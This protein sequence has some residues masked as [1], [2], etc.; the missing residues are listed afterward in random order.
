LSIHYY[1][2]LFHE[3]I[4]FFNLLYTNVLYICQIMDDALMDDVIT[5]RFRKT[6]MRAISYSIRD[7]NHRQMHAYALRNPAYM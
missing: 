1:T 7:M 3:N 2:L 6:H 4:S 5:A